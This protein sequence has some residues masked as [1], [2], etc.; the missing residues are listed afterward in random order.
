MKIL[1]VHNDYGKYSGEESVVDQMAVM[2]AEHGHQVVQL[3]MSTADS[4]DSL[5]GKMHGF[6]AG[7]YSPKGVREMHRI[8]K[9]ERPDVVNVHNLY[10]F[11]S[12]AA[13]F[14]C[15]KAGV[16]VVMTVHNFRLICPT[17]LFMRDGKPCELCLER[18]NEWDC[19]RYNCEHSLLK[20]V[21][22]AA[23]NAV[24]RYSGAYR[25]CV[26]R[27][28]CIT[29]FQRQKLIQAGFDATKIVVIPN[30]VVATSDY[31]PAVGTY[32]AY[33]GRLSREK[34][35]DLIVEVARRH[36][37]ITFRFAGALRD[38]DIVENL[39]TNVTLVGYL[40]GEELN[41]FYKGAAFFVMASRWYE[42]FPV[43]ILEAAQFGKPTIGPNHGG[44]TEI[45]GEGD[46]AIGRLF[47]PGDVDALEQQIV[48][49]WNNPCEITRLG[50]K[51]HDKLL[52]EYST[53]V[54]YQEWNDLIKSILL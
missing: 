1:L 13:L 24:A 26:D 11:I 40:H 18:G 22:Y 15:K 17:G 52:R 20:S 50:E 30:A 46:A 10:P 54:I 21:G 39:P 48:S 29:D 7:L 19:V 9:E 2:W 6:L 45:I 34:G 25:K 32:V 51:A 31:D 41:A 16:P 44:F 37:E 36:P 8:L 28:A 43:S 47:A 23:R 14:E 4:W 42:G 5:G 49:L 12:P 53:E 35:V 3:R 38:P 27:F 33:S